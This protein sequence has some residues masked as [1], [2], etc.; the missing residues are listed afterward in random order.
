MYY[1]H[2]YYETFSKFVLRIF[3]KYEI[4]VSS[5]SVNLSDVDVNSIAAFLKSSRT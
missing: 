1:W 4:R 2:E 5:F 3:K